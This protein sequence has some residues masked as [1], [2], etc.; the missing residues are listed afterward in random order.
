MITERSQIPAS[1][2]PAEH[3]LFGSLEPKVTHATKPQTI[4]QDI[5]MID[6]VDDMKSYPTHVALSGEGKSGRSGVRNDRNELCTASGDPL[7]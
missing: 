7:S 6:V 2:G 4:R 3:S 5:W 1:F